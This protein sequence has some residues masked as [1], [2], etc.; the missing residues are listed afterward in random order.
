ML[1]LRLVRRDAR[2]DDDK[3]LVA[4]GAL[5]VA[6][7][8]NRYAAIQQRGHFFLQ[9]RFGL[10]VGNDDLSAVF[11]QKNSRR[12]AGAPQPHHQN[13][14]VFQLHLKSHCAMNLALRK[15]KSTG[16]ARYRNFKVVSANNAKISARIQNRIMIL[17]SDHPASSKWWCSGAILN[18]RFLRSL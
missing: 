11:L 1:Q 17:D 12:H 5:A 14:F 4:K 15:R 8:L 18:T 10:G 7:G 6:A 3:I 13:P 2:A 16:C 9:L